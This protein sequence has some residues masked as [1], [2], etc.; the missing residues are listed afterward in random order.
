MPLSALLSRAFVAFTVEVDNEFEHRM[1]HRTSIPGFGRGGRGPWLTSLVMWSTCLRFVDSHGIALAELE[2]RARTPTNLA[3]M[4]RWGYVVVGPD[5]ADG[6]PRPRRSEWPIRAT[7]AGERAREVWA[8]VPALVE[9]RWEERFGQAVVDRLRAVLRTVVGELDPGL[10]DCLPILGY[11]LFSRIPASVRA[12]EPRATGGVDALPLFALLARIL[13]AIAIEFEAGSVV[14]LAI[15]ADVMRPL[16][17]A[18]LRLRDLP[19]MSGVSKEAISMAL[20]VLVK[21]HLARVAGDPDGPQVKVAGLTSAGRIAFGADRRR[22][23]TIEEHLERATPGEAGR[24]LRAALEPLV[25]VAGPESAVF[26]GLTPY[27]DGWRASVPRPTTL[28][29]FPMILHRGGYPDG[30]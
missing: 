28:P 25:G 7:P 22:L 13:L 9:L 1:P 19:R 14:S 10:P 5:P 12:V 27:P 3:G 11:G 24:E 2:R 20:G 4:E 6:R 18:D 17:G 16:A 8:A 29:E 26:R 15:H 23:A 30:S 21:G